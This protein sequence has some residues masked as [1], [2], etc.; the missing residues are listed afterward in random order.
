MGGY[1]AGLFASAAGI[2]FVNAWY[3]HRVLRREGLTPFQKAS[4]AAP[5]VVD[6]RL[7]YRFIA[8]G[9]MLGYVKLLHR[10]ADV[11]LVA[12]FCGDR[13][14]GLYKLARS[15]A[16][17][18]YAVSEAIG[19][20]YQPRFL[21]SLQARNHSAYV[22]EARSV[23]AI[24][25]FVTT[26]AIAAE[27]TLLPWLAPILGVTGVAD[28]QTLT[29]C[30]AVLTLS[31]LFAA[32]VQSWIWPALVYTGRLGRCAAWG[33]F[34]V[35]A[36]QYGLGPVALY[37]AGDGS[38]FWLCVGYLSFYPLSLLPLWRELP[39]EWSAFPWRIQEVPAR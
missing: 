23:T 27:L 15:I 13:E 32:G 33:T 3:T 35:I 16:D 21:A 24:V 6:R 29:L 7:L 12:V 17:A 4:A 37:L 22:A 14:T 28:I 2:A 11:L 30:V 34:A 1:A 5:L 36:G 39:R 18:L 25:A 19:R 31:F 20:V 9:N 26:A 38:P 8:A 10:S